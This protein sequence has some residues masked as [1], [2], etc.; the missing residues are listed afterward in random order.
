MKPGLRVL[1]SVILCLGFFVL[2]TS[3]VKPP[4]QAEPVEFSLFAPIINAYAELEQS[5]FETYDED[6][7]NPVLWGQGV[8]Y[9]YGTFGIGSR[10]DQYPNMYY[11]FYDINRDGISE[12]LIGTDKSITGIYTLRNSKPV[13]AIQVETRHTLSLLL[14]EAGN[15]VIEHSWGRMDVAEDFFYTIDGNSDL[16]VLDKLYTDGRDRTADEEYILFRSKEVDG[17]QVDITEAEY[18]SL[19]WKYGGLG[20]GLENG[21][22]I[23]RI[24]LAWKPIDIVRPQ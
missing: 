12:L 14:D 3:C 7:V 4:A 6:I 17:A 19:V 11:A 21:E 22:P 15:P 23:R 10:E 2:I 20:Y 9:N 5:G 16:A 24:E 13:S 8:L 18:S 1:R